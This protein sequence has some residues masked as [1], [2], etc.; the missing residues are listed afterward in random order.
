[1]VPERC[2]AQDGEVGEAKMRW[3]EHRLDIREKIFIG[4]VVRHWKRLPSAG[5]TV[6]GRAG[7]CGMGDR[8]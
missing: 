3:A 6:L 4:M 2:L 1:M 8:V 7:G 5:I